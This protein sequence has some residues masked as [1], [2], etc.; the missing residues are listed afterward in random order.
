[1]DTN[2]YCRPLDDQ[3]I[4]WI[5]N[6]TE[7]IVQI[8]DV[9]ARKEVIIIGSNILGKETKNVSDTEKR[10]AALRIIDLSSEHIIFRRA[11]EGLAR[12]ILTC[13]V[14]EM[15][16]L[17]IASSCFGEAEHFLTCDVQILNRKK[18]IEKIVRKEGYN[19]NVLNPINFTEKIIGG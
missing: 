14:N 16:S 11:I 7:A 10:R 3:S 6:E 5:R 1:M 8:L 13:N 15:D 9:A 12:K 18:C 17:H 2:V 19:L 4:D